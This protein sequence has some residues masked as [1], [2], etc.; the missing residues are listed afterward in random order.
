[1]ENENNASPRPELRS[2]PS[3]LAQMDEARNDM[4][5]GRGERATFDAWMAQGNANGASESMWKAWQAALATQSSAQPATDE[6]M[7]RAALEQLENGALNVAANAKIRGDDYDV[8]YAN[9]MAKCAREALAT[10]ASA[11][12]TEDSIAE[13]YDEMLRELCCFLSVGG[14][15]SAGLIDPAIAGAKI[16]DGID[17]MIKVERE[18]AVAQ[19]VSAQP[20]P[21]DKIPQEVTP[22]FLLNAAMCIESP[23]EVATSRKRE[24]LAS[25]HRVADQ[26]QAARMVAHRTVP[27]SQAVAEARSAN[28]DL[29]IARLEQIAGNFTDDPR[30]AAHEALVCARA[31]A[32]ASQAVSSEAVAYL[33]DKCRCLWRDNR[34]GTMSLYSGDQK[35]CSTCET[36][37]L[38]KLTPMAIADH[39]F[40]EQRGDGMFASKE[41]T[42]PKTKHA[43]PAANGSSSTRSAPPM[44][45]LQLSRPASLSAPTVAG[46]SD[47]ALL[48][49][50]TTHTNWEISSES[51]DGDLIWNVHKVVGSVND[52]EWAKIGSGSTP[53]AAIEQAIAAKGNMQ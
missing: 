6:P 7:L 39:L 43:A 17:S 49:T 15:N 48:D 40:I 12:P 34:D 46:L 29:V 20:A 8:G 21:T 11:Q 33:C 38:K 45:P 51:D 28:L 31:I 18:R 50:L 25:L 4:D 10:P 52:R 41:F 30:E 32:P 1:M 27:A 9:S 19:F 23:H 13:R 53:R 3:N 26:M 36:M 16:R 42:A 24:V 14:Y 35:S 2:P 44:P 5:M 22:M 47:A 37:P